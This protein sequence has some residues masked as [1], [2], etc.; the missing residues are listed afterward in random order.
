[1]TTITHTCPNCGRTR[2]SPGLCPACN[3][4]ARDEIGSI[5]PG[6]A[7]ILRL[8]WWQFMDVCRDVYR[9]AVGEVFP[10]VQGERRFIVLV[11]SGATAILIAAAWASLK[12]AG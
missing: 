1:M 5:L 10:V 3:D 9:F 8:I 11:L 6:L 7:W 12:L 2:R 4:Q